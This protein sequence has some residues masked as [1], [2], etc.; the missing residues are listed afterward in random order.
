VLLEDAGL[1]DEDFDQLI[2]VASRALTTE[3]RGVELAVT[4]HQNDGLTAVRLRIDG[5]WRL[6]DLYDR[7]REIGVCDAAVRRWDDVSG[8]L[9]TRRAALLDV[10]FDREGIVAKVHIE[11]RVPPGEVVRWTSQLDH[12]LDR[13]GVSERQRAWMR[14]L[15]P[16]LCE[17]TINAFLWTITVRRDH[18]PVEFGLTLPRVPMSMVLKHG[19]DLH[20]EVDSMGLRLGALMGAFEREDDEVACWGIVLGGERPRGW[21]GV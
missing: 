19:L 15:H 8:T 20:P 2:D 13:L 17:R 21:I 11:R 7:L 16:A 10:G 1:A 9:L 4:A 3:G 6:L 12:V 18:V 5:G 14:A